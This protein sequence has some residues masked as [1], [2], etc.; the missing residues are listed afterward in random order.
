LPLS[1]LS[2]YEF[3]CALNDSVVN[4]R[5]VDRAQA[6]NSL[7]FRI[8]ACNVHYASCWCLPRTLAVLLSIICICG[9]YVL[10]FQFV[11][12]WND[13]DDNDAGDN[14]KQQSC[15]DRY[16]S[17]LLLLCLSL[18]SY[19]TGSCMFTFTFMAMLRSC[20]EM[21]LH[22]GI[23]N[24]DWYSV[25]MSLNTEANCLHVFLGIWWVVD[26]FPNSN[27]TLGLSLSR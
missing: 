27:T 11:S 24:T 14:H 9:V 4:K 20:S 22:S 18:V 17:S 16:L 6:S 8:C 2:G 19:A 21:D 23:Q 25:S 26:K 3:M 7:T 13:H 15:L 10:K 1:L 5:R 12:E